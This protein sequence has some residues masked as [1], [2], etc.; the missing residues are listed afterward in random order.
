MIICWYSVT[1]QFVHFDQKCQ[2]QDEKSHNDFCNT[3]FLYYQ[4]G[5]I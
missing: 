4:W 1:F 2:K 5:V 3:L